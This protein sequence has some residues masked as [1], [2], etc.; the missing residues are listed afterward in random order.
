MYESCFRMQSRRV[1]QCT[2]L[3]PKKML[4]FKL[5]RTIFFQ[6][7]CKKDIQLG[8]NNLLELFNIVMIIVLN[9]AWIR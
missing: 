4:M 8:K 5:I 6:K 3:P 7:T 2:K 9:K 1:F